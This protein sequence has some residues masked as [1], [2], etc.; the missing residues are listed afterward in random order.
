MGIGYLF[1]FE[2]F[3]DIRCDLSSP[4]PSFLP[5]FHRFVAING[6]VIVDLFIVDVSIIL[7]LAVSDPSS[8]SNQS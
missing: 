5:L 3:V 4:M 6:D 7:L 8:G 2:L 1:T